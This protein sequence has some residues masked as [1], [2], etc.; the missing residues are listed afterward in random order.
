MA[1]FIQDGKVIN[2]TLAANAD[3]HDP[4][5]VGARLGVVLAAGLATEVVPVAM[6]GVFMLPTEAS[7]LSVGAVVYLVSGKIV[8]AIG[9]DET[10]ITAGY[11]AGAIA[12]GYVPVKIN[13]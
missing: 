10:G 7:S 2:V 12:S 13:A 11:V 9:Q 8:S 1:D 6:E 5:V 3:Y 4:I